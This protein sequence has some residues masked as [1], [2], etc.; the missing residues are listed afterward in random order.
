[1]RLTHELQTI[2]VPFLFMFLDVDECVTLSPCENGATCVD[3]TDGYT[4]QCTV[5]WLGTNCTGIC[6]NNIG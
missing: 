3:E 4:C 5:E 6:N 2:V 1:M